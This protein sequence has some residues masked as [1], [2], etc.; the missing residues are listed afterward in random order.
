MP[1]F[2]ETIGY[3]AKL[4]NFKDGEDQNEESQYQR[5]FESDDEEERTD[6]QGV[7][8]MT[9]NLIDLLTTLV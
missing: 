8:G 3:R 6:S 5:G 4:E 2:T 7:D 9:Q 1:V